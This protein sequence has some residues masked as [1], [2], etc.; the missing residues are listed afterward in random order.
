MERTELIEA[1]KIKIKSLNRLLEGQ[2]NIIDIRRLEAKRSCYRVFITDLERLAND[3]TNASGLNIPVVS[4]RYDLKVGY[5][6][7]NGNLKEVIIN[8][9]DCDEAYIKFKK[10]FGN[11]KVEYID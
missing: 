10:Q 9:T 4:E 3:Y 2:S 8:A 5:K 11:I 6:N 1:Y 7:E